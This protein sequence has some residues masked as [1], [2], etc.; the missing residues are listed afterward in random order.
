MVHWNGHQLCVIDTETTGLDPYYCEMIQIAIV[1]LDS[2]I[3]PRQDIVPFYIDI[4]PEHPERIEK[5][6]LE[7]NKINLK[8]IM[9]HGFD[10]YKA[11]DL[12][13]EW[14]KKLDLPVTSAGTPKK[15]LPLG[16]NFGFDRGF[17]QMWLGRAQYDEW[18]HYHYKDTMIAAA[19]L[20]DR[21]AMKAEKVPFSKI[22]LSWLCNVLKVH[23][24]RSHDALQD[25]LATAEVYRKLLNQDDYSGLLA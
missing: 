19:F 3:K 14:M 25:C 15:I 8:R 16:Q 11:I 6:A 24:E 9:S 7:I 20:N 12:L 23:R 18:F 5:G 21:A 4:K 10:K 13:E 1:A 2:D 17:M 22:S